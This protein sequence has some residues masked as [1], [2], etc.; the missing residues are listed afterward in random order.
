MGRGGKLI[1]DFPVEQ[2]RFN[3]ALVARY[4]SIRDAAKETGVPYSQIYACVNGVTRKAA[5]Y[6]WQRAEG[7]G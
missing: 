5:G 2:R 6:R 1:L 4:A 7:E 3:G